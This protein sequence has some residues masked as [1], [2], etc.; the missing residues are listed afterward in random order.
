MNQA[1]CTL[2]IFRL[3]DC[4]EKPHKKD[5]LCKINLCSYVEPD[6]IKSFERLTSS[7]HCDVCRI[8]GEINSVVAVTMKSA[9]KDQDPEK[10]NAAPGENGLMALWPYGLSGCFVCILSGALRRLSGLSIVPLQSRWGCCSML[11]RAMDTG[12]TQS[13]DFRHNRAHIG[14]DCMV[15]PP[16]GT[17]A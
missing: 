4:G 7:V 2:I 13:P 9:R 3:N 12:I 6:W 1:K 8:S 14:R 10:R 11:N 16:R 17:K 5:Q 15:C